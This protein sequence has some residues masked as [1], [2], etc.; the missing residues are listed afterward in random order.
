KGGRLVEKF[1]GKASITLVLSDVE[2]NDLD[3]IASGP[4]VPDPTTYLDANNILIK[5][6]LWEE[7][8]PCC[9]HIMKGL[10]GMFAET[11]KAKSPN[12]DIYILADN[13]TPVQAAI[14]ELNKSGIT[15]IAVEKL[16]GNAVD[17][18]KNLRLLLENHSAVVAG[19]E[20]TVK[21]TGCGVGG[22]NQELVLGSLLLNSAGKT[23]FVAASIGTDGVDGTSKFAGGLVTSNMICQ[24]IK[25]RLAL[26][27]NDS[28]A[29]LES[30]SL[31]IM[32]GPSGTNLNDVCIFLRIK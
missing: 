14:K 21:V 31:A 10:G 28:S 15:D 32:T 4:T 13:M 7:S 20:T 24:K 9:K 30:N 19:G 22:R 2:G 27:N 5:Y 12:N 29:F 11:P 8:N 16:K 26:E 25:V 23:K 18:G 3:V 17:A 6:G 1:R